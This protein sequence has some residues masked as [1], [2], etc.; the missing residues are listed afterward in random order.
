MSRVKASLLVIVG[1]HG[2]A[3][4]YNTQTRRKLR[5]SLR[6]S[7]ADGHAAATRDTA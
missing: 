1:G 2:W 6:F 7:E 3:H 5:P 4:F